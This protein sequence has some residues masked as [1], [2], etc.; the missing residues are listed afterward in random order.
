MVEFLPPEPV[1]QKRVLELNLEL[2]EVKDQIR[3]LEYPHGLAYT[4]HWRVRS[5]TPQVSSY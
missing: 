4:L 2:W 3:L 5:V 1:V